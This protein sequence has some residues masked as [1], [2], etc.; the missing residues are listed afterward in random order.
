MVI[1][2]REKRI[3]ILGDGTRKIVNGR[4]EKKPCLGTRLDPGQVLAL[5]DVPEERR[6]RFLA[7]VRRQ[8][9][10]GYKLEV[11]AEDPGKD[12]TGDELEQMRR[13]K[14]LDALDALTSAPPPAPK[15]GPGRP[16]KNPPL[17]G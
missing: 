1:V 11:L 10:K 16:R 9:S 6:E 17:G 8:I 3:M 14:N 13:Q 12:V 7:S 4:E 5:E 2:N 15:R